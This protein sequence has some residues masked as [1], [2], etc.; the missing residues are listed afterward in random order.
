MSRLTAT[1]VEKIFGSEAAEAETDE[2]LREYFYRNPLF[3]EIV[4]DTPFKVVTG[5]K[6]TGKSALMRM[7][8]LSDVSKE[9]VA[10]WLTPDDLGASVY[11]DAKGRDREPFQDNMIR[12]IRMWKKALWQIVANKTS[13]DYASAERGRDLIKKLDPVQIRLTELLRVTNPPRQHARVA[14]YIDDLDRA[15]AGKTADQVA[16][17]GLIYALRDMTREN[18]SLTAR[19]SLRNDVYWDVRSADQG[20]DKIEANVVNVKWSLHEIL[21]MLVKRVITWLGQQTD[22]HVLSRYRQEALAQTLETLFEPRMP[23]RGPW[24]GR[25]THKVLLSLVR[26]RPRDMVKLCT[27]AARAAL[28]DRRSTITGRD[29]LQII[30]EYSRGRIQD[31]I[32]EFMQIVPPVDRLVYGMRPTNK[33]LT[34]GSAWHYRTDKLLQKI[35]NVLSQTSLGSSIDPLQASHWLYK[36][37]FLTARYDY[38]DGYIERRYFDDSPHLLTP[39]VGD[40][41]FSWEV[42]PAYREALSPRKLHDWKALTDVESWISEEVRLPEDAV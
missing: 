26:R 34:E 13:E 14:L 15:W 29:I 20:L 16:V 7:S 38:P 5:F 24:A 4:S 36:M 12:A 41:G 6:G 21:V 35:K 23:S 10:L 31:L 39:A 33:E 42:H 22:E 1:D 2:R 9:V 17:A 27:F 37:G 3:D 19:M 25:P 8:L 11:R 18:R 30:P 40:G 28:H 32:N